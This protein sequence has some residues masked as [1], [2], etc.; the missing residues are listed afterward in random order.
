MAYWNG[1]ETMDDD[2]RRALSD[3][4]GLDRQ[5]VALRWSTKIPKD[6]PKVEAKA[7]F[8]TKLDRASRGE[9]LYSTAT[10]EECMGGAKYCGLRDSKS[11][12]AGRRSGKFLV[13]MGV[14]KSVPAVQRAWRDYVLIEPGIFK[15]LSFA[16]LADATFD[17]DVVVVICNGK[18]AMELLHANSYDSGA[19]AIG[20][21]SGPICSSMAALPYMTGKVTYG[22]ADVGSREH[23]TLD[24]CEV[25]VSIP[26]SEV[27]RL[28]S[29]LG[30]MRTKSSFRRRS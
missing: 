26:G 15:A 27:T 18:Q 2:V 14:Y 11:F 21:D 29:N 17:P 20:A 8:C 6:I 10:D 30:E 22:F 16:P 9:Q 25:M 13:G 5:P 4:L 3:I 7:R 19:H 23:M 12:N 1:D 24:D 28:T